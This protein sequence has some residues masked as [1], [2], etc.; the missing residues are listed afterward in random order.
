MA[1]ININ[2]KLAQEIVDAVNTVVDKDINF[3]DKNGRIIASTDEE[4][5]STF[6]EAGYEAI[7]ICSNVTVEHAD[8]YKGSKKGINYPIMINKTPIGVIGITGEP[9]EVSKFGFLVTK[10]TEIFVKEQ[11]LNYKFELDKQ[12]IHYVVKSLIYNNIEDQNNIGEI[13]DEF[14]ISTNDEMAVVIIKINNKKSVYK[15][16][17][18]ENDI[19]QFFRKIGVILNIYIYIQMKL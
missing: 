8:Q 9:I 5:I 15:L 11:Q 17:I 10:I 7:E 16:D 2:K 3:I 13:L 19:K 4:R 1:N 14:N 6:H 18:I 12:R